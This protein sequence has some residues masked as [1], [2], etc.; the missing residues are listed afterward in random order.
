MRHQR[1]PDAVLQVVLVIVRSQH[2][3]GVGPGIEV[4]THATTLYNS[5]FLFDQD[6]MVNGHAYG[7]PAG[8]SPVMHLRRVPGGRTWDYYMRSFDEVWNTGIPET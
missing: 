8:H 4:R 3:R 5:L 1:T 6:L 2:P 7:A